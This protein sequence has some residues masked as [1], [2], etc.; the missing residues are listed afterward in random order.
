M[1][2]Q[3]FIEY[4]SDK[5]SKHLST[6]RIQSIAASLRQHGLGI[7]NTT[8]N[9]TYQFLAQKFHIFNQFLFD[10]YIRAHLS[11]EMR[12][13]KKHKNEA[14]VDNRYPYDRAHK[15]VKDIRKQGVF[16]GNKTC[17]DQMRILITEIG[18]ALGYVRMVRSA[19]MYHCSEAVMFLPELED[20]IKFESFTKPSETV[21]AAAEGDASN[22]SAEAADEIHAPFASEE[23]QR[24]AKNVD[25]VIGKCSVQIETVLD[26][27]SYMMFFSLC[28]NPGIEFWRRI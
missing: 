26:C 5:N 20:L 24:A 19:S 14:G 7:L 4:R 21:P 18:N 16:D 17:L 22:P 10:E 15:F 25:D 8:V 12:W 1:N 11:R 6:I 9:Y 13:F 2:M 3:Q 23:T 27:F 28:R